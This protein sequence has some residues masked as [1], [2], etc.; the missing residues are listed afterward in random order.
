MIDEVEVFG[1]ED[2]E[3]GLHFL[4]EA[5][6]RGIVLTALRRAAEFLKA[7]IIASIRSTFQSRSGDMISAVQVETSIEPGRR[8]GSIVRARVFSAP[9]SSKAPYWFF[10]E[11]G[12]QHIGRSK[13]LSRSLRHQARA[14]K[15]AG[16]DIRAAKSGIGTFMRKAAWKPAF[17]ANVQ[18]ALAII[19]A[20]LRSGFDAAVDQVFA[21]K[22]AA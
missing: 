1:I 11:K 7:K 3:R 22:R 8:G 19:V 10:W 14:A 21:G 16:E 2:V 17:E 18:Q 9:H 5:M 6:A 15:R 12:F 13:K 20:E 4:P